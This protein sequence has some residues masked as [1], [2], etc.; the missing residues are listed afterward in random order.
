MRLGV[1]REKAP[2]L[3]RLGV[4]C[5]TWNTLG[6]RSRSGFCSTWNIDRAVPFRYGFN[7]EI[8]PESDKVSSAKSMSFPLLE[9]FAVPPRGLGHTLRKLFSLMG[10]FTLRVGTRGALST[11]GTGSPHCKRLPSARRCLYSELPWA[12]S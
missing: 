3:G 9:F 10:L 11:A 1:E 12:R 5:S 6:Q 8:R 4:R 7:L 2:F